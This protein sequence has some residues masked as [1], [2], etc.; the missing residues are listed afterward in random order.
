MTNR[1]TAAVAAA[2]IRVDATD[3]RL[4]RLTT[5]MGDLLT[6]HLQGLEKAIPDSIQVE[7][8][9]RMIAYLY[10]API[11]PGTGW[12]SLF[13]N[14]GASAIV[15][16]WLKKVGIIVGTLLTNVG[17][18]VPGGTGEPGMTEEEVQALINA[19]LVAHSNLP[20]IHHTPPDV[21]PPQVIPPAPTVYTLMVSKRTSGGALQGQVETFRSLTKDFVITINPTATA[22]RIRL[23]AEAGRSIVQVVDV[24]DGD[25]TSDFIPANNVS[26]SNGDYD[27]GD[28]IMLVRT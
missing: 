18:P 10:D 9:L 16:P 17:N 11:G 23:E 21:P 8:H 27:G 3:P 28:R 6:K 24:M 25:I 14:S 1:A 5:S 12:S 4:I 7:A 2:E 20:N 15:R 22:P 19:A 26:I 13:L